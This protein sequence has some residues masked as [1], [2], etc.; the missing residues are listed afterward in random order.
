MDKKWPNAA[1]RMSGDGLTFDSLHASLA[2]IKSPYRDSTMHLEEKYTEE[3]A[4]YVF[5]MVKGLM[6]KIAARMDEYGEPKLP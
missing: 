3:E 5:E 6:T 2:A 4:R 1:D